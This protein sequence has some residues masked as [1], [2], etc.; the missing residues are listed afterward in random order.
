MSSSKLSFFEIRGLVGGVRGRQEDLLIGGGEED[1]RE[2][3]RLPFENKLVTSLFVLMIILA[4]NQSC[5]DVPIFVMC[6]C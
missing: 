1:S 6:W 4:A 3:Q 2:H 5:K